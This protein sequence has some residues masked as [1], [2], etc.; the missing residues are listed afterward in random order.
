MFAIALPVVSPTGLLMMFLAFCLLALPY[1]YERRRV[2]SLA[3]AG[4][5]TYGTATDMRIVVRQGDETF[6]EE[7][8]AFHQA[9]V[10]AGAVILYRSSID[11]CV[12][13]RSFVSSDE[14]WSA[15]VAVV[16]RGV[17]RQHRSHTVPWLR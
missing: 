9:K 4:L 6:N 14:S 11:F 3:S 1:G 16:R 13:S 17:P 8:A 12:I 15:F 7:W 2:S 10:L 5:D